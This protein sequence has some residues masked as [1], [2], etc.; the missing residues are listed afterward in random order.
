MNNGAE[1]QEHKILRADAL[2]GLG[3]FDFEP[4]QSAL[5]LRTR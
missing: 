4:L 1:E 3:H 5:K 2:A